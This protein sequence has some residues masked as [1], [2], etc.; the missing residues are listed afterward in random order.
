MN[1]KFE[2]YEYLFPERVYHCPCLRLAIEECFFNEENSR[3][4]NIA[5]YLADFEFKNKLLMSIIFSAILGENKEY[6]L[7]S[8][9]AHLRTIILGMRKFVCMSVENEQTVSIEYSNKKEVYCVGCVRHYMLL[10]Y[11]FFEF[12][13]F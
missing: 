11:N 4:A 10:A 3:I 6:R 13:Q 1:S 2:K 7:F 5:Y 8:C 9:E 12:V